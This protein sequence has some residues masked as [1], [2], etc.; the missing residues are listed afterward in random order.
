[1]PVRVPLPI[2]DVLPQILSALQES[3]TL[4]LQASPGSGKT[5]RVPPALL[6]LIS[7]QI[8]VLEPRRLAAR[9]SAERVSAEEN[10]PCGGKIGYQIR[11][12]N[13]TS[14]STRIKFVTEGLFLRSLL[15]DPTL[16]QVGCVI[17][18]EFH[19]RHIHTDVAL[20]LTRH[21]QTSVRPDLKLVV[22][23]A[24][25]DA[26]RLLKFIPEARVVT[27]EGRK[28]PVDVEHAQLTTKLALEHQVADAVTALLQ[29]ARCPGHILCFLPGAADI[30]RAFQAVAPLAEKKGAVVL[31]LR[32][33]LPLAEQQKVFSDLGKR[34]II[35]STNVAETSVTI[36][37]VTGVVD[38]GLAKIAGHAAWSGLSTL[39]VK[40]ISQ[41]ASIQRA[42]RAGRTV[43]GV[44][45]RLFT[46]QEFSGRQ[47][48][49]KPEIQ[50]MDFTQIQL[51]LTVALA[52][53]SAS[54]PLQVDTLPW[55]E[56]PSP[57]GLDS[58]KSTLRL[59]GALDKENKMTPAGEWLAKF[60]LHPRLARIVQAG[61]ELGMG[62]QALL[63]ATLLSEG[64]L[65]KRNLDDFPDYA[66]SDVSYQM[67]VFQSLAK[68]EN[69]DSRLRNRV[70]MTSFKR[71]E[72]LLKMLL[73]SV[74]AKWADVLNPIDEEILSAAL[75]AGY[76][77]R[78][79]QVK[80]RSSH[81]SN[82]RGEKVELALC[83]GGSAVLARTSV[84]RDSEF[85]IALDAEETTRGVSSSE[86]IQVRV[87]SGIEKEVL[88][89]G[90]A[91]LLKE[92]EE[93]YWDNDAERVRAVLR[94]SYGRL[95]VS[96]KPLHK[97]SPAFEEVLQKELKSRWPKPFDEEDARSLEYLQI[98]CQLVRECGFDF[99]IPDFLGEDFEF[100][101]AHICEGKKSFE[102]IL[103]REM[104]EYIDD[105]LSYESR[106]LLEE[107]A[108][109]K[110]TIGAG[111]KVKVH[112]EDKK[113]PWVASK[114]QDFFG[115]LKTPTVAR[116]RVA[117]VVHL[118]A[119]N[120]QAVQVTN[121]LAG[122]WERVYPDVKKELSRKYPRHSWPEDPKTAL[123]PEPRPPRKRR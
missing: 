101:L 68:G 17:L 75:L 118:L 66:H 42:G 69:M 24:T 3:S 53:I 98:R 123:P 108:P 32:A 84:V 50:R 100:L 99:A 27:W 85:L 30:R 94:R 61:T 18:D 57:Q 5:T 31:E 120:T 9:L 62:A 96:E 48:F 90:P 19:E 26:E 95:V 10:E 41:A 39:D 40:A 4:I 51:E 73:P 79:A 43:A 88:E 104:G 72:G 78:V 28:F 110:I 115:T 22:M 117:L 114:L 29:D 49:E 93:Y 81:K 54:R 64:M 102:E 8:L 87:A 106:K 35:L 80:N 2:D 6:P 56:A 36:D 76:P 105:L 12:E 44:A 92:G 70:D 34:K 25:L 122:F 16:S 46:Q 109:D 111:R 13:V 107:L 103:D 52:R 74:P 83:L 82:Q 65:F 1:M 119:P 63:A 11:F 20:A 116:G 7:K 97:V 121:D 91:E 47:S 37:G 112:Y 58:A 14:K 59:I 23:S 45:K 86:S 113:P 77:D 71:V 15:Q 60:P 33:E 67:R 38:C 89:M 21:L 55:F